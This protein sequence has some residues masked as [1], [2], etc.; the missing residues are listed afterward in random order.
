MEA[1][2]GGVEELKQE[3]KN[4]LRTFALAW[5]EEAEILL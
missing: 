3:E 5:G 1:E 4:E 2:R